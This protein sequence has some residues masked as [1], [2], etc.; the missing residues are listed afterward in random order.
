MDTF[1][2]KVMQSIQEEP[3]YDSL[4]AIQ[5]SVWEQ[6]RKKRDN[7][8]KLSWIDIK[9]TPPLKA[10]SL[11]L[12]LGS[13]LALTQLDFREKKQPDLFDL[14]YFSNQSLAT[15]HLLSYSAEGVSQ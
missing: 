10:V 5:D 8:G 4:T 9:F 6:I 1:D 7:G 3:N 12:I 15:S 11:A 13:F 14:R 2:K